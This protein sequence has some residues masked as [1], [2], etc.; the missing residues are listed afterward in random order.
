MAEYI[1][2]FG[3]YDTF[4]SQDKVWNDGC[5][6]ESMILFCQF[7]AGPNEKSATCAANSMILFCQ[8]TKACSAGLSGIVNPSSEAHAYIDK[9]NRKRAKT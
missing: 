2:K 5:G 1:T 4:L 8:S 3:K 6:L 9:I 7:E